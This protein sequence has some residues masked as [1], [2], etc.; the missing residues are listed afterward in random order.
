MTIGM[1]TLSKIPCHFTVAL[2]ARAAPASPPMR[3]WDDDEGRPN[4]QVSRFQPMAPTNAAP[5]TT[6]APVPLGGPMMPLQTV[7]ATFLPKKAPIML[8][9]AAISRATRGVSALVDTE[10]AMA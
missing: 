5:T 9:M 10:V 7:S 2:A 6:R 8:Q 1:M 3:A 4:H